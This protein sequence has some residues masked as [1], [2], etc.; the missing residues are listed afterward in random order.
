MNT[1]TELAPAPIAA[2][3]PPRPT[4]FFR[5]WFSGCPADQFVELR[6]IHAATKA[7]HQE[8]YALDAVHQL[9]G[10]ACRFVDDHDVYFG[11][12]P[13]VRPQGRNQD[14]THTPG[15]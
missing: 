2:T 10:D 8:F 4:E 6:S 7:V 5:Q 15:L 12:C 1:V 14:V 13:R 3:S 11:V 9:Y